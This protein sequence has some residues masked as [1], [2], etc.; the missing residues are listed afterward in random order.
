MT[1][2]SQPY[3]P[4]ACALH[5]QYEIAIMFRSHINISWHE[6]NKEQHTAEVL[7]VDLLVK[8][9]E[10]FLVARNADNQELCIR[11]DRIEL[12]K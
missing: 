6:D 11:L 4:I 1:D 12:H 2:T 9:G 3:K 8:N 7:P 10:E 5:D